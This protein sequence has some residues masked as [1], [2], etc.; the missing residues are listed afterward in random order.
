M[1]FVD[2]ISGNNVTSIHVGDTVQWVWQGTMYHGVAAGTC[3]A[4]GGYGGSNCTPTGAWDSTAHAGPFTYSHTFTQ[5]G[6]FPYFCDVHLGA[7]TGVV[8]VN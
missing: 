8:H 3:T 4:G 2:Q 6:S 7:M 5:A 1:R